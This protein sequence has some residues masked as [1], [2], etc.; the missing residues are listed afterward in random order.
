M[1]TEFPTT[2]VTLGMG[3][4]TTTEVGLAAI[5]TLDAAEV[6][7]LTTPAAIETS[8]DM[9]ELCAETPTAGLATELTA[10]V[11]PTTE[12]PADKT[13]VETTFDGTEAAAVTETVT[14][15]DAG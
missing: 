15:V 8:S 1:T 13:V 7:A 10:D 9:T 14:S 4:V 2:G 5:T 12:V 6:A 11:M 3:T